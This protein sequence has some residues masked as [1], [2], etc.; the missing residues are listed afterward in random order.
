M[1][2]LAWQLLLYE[3]D[4]CTSGNTSAVNADDTELQSTVVVELVV[5]SFLQLLQTN[6]VKPK[7]RKM[8]FIR[9]FLSE[10]IRKV[11]SS[12]TKEL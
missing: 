7:S 3:Q 9:M 1:L 12:K 11:Y 10:P 4:D 6:S 8:F 2:P 5:L